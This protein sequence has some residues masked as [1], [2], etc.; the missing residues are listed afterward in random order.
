MA[1]DNTNTPPSSGKRRDQT[2][3]LFTAAHKSP[4]TFATGTMADQATSVCDLTEKLRQI[5]LIDQKKH[6]LGTYA[7][8]TDG[9]IATRI[10]NPAFFVPI[11]YTAASAAKICTD[12]AA[13]GAKLSDTELVYNPTRAMLDFFQ[14][15]RRVC[16]VREYR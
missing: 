14:Q 2:P 9:I 12:N 16:V 7:C 13:S 5:R 11:V 4:D 6:E 10:K 1:G 8:P 3:F 15:L